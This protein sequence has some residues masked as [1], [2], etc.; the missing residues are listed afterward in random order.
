[1]AP[2]TFEYTITGRARC[3]LYD[4]ADE[5]YSQYAFFA[6][7]FATPQTPQDRTS[8]PFQEALREYL[9]R[10]YA[11]VK[12]RFH[13]ALHPARFQTG[14]RV[15]PAGKAG[16]ILHNTTLEQRRGSVLPRRRTDRDD[17]NSSAGGGGAAAAA[18]PPLP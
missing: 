4:L 17:G 7:S 11:D 14:Q 13:V 16:S 1:M 2:Q 6:T 9:V 10:L 12:S 3:L 15:V 8:N 5:I 18:C